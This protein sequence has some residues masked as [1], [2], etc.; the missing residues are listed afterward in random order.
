MEVSQEHL[1]RLLALACRRNV[2]QSFSREGQLKPGDSVIT[3]AGGQ[4]H[5]KKSDP[6][7]G[8]PS[9]INLTTRGRWGQLRRAVKGSLEL[10]EM[11][12]CLSLAI[13]AI[14]ANMGFPLNLCADT[15]IKAMKEH[16]D[17]R[18]GENT[19][20]QIHFVS[21]ND[22]AVHA[23]E[24][25]VRDKFGNHGITYSQ[26]SG[27]DKQ[28][29]KH[30][31][32]S[33]KLLKTNV[34]LSIQLVEG[35]IQDATTEVIVNVVGTELDLGKGAVS[36][37]VLGA[38]G[39]Q[40]Q[41]LVSE[42]RK[43][44]NFG[45]VI[46]TG[47]CKLKSNVVFHAVV[48]PWDNQGN[49]HKM[50]RGIVEDCLNEAHKRGLTSITFPAIGTG[51]LDF[52]KDLAA[53]VMIEEVLKFKKQPSG[54]KTVRHRCLSKRQRDNS[55]R[56]KNYIYKVHMWIRTFKIVFKDELKKR[57]STTQ[58]VPAPLKTQS[59]L[60]SKV[61]SASGMHEMTIGHVSVQV[62]SGDIT[63]ET[64]DVIVNSSNPSFDLKTGV[65]KAILDA[66]GPTV[67]HECTILGGQPNTG[68][69]MTK[70]GNLKC[71]KILHL[72]GRNDPQDIQLAV[73]AAL[74]LVEQNRYTSISFPALGTGQGNAQ[75]GQVADAMLDAVVD[76]V[77]QSAQSCLK[78]VRIVIFQPAM[79]KDFLS[80]M[81]KKA[82]SDKQ[83]SS[84]FGNIHGKLKGVV[85]YL[86]GG[87]AATKVT[88]QK[89]KNLVLDELQI[90]S[91][92]FHIC[93]SSQ[94]QVNKAITWIDELISNDYVETPITDRMILNLSHADYQDIGVIQSTMNVSVKINDERTS[95]TLE[96]LTKNVH[97][98]NI[99]IQNM[100][101]KIRDDEDIRKILESI[102]WQYQ[103]QGVQFQSFDST[104][105]FLLEQANQNN[106]P[107][108][109][110]DIRGRVY[111]VNMPDGPA[112]DVQGNTV[113]IRRHDM[114]KDQDA[115]NLPQHWDPMPSG[116]TCHT[117]PITPGTQEYNDV[118]QLFQA[119]CQQ[120]VIKIDRIQNASLWKSLQ[121]KKQDMDMMNG[122]QNNEKRLFHGAC[123]TSITAIN[124][125]GFNRSYAGK[126]AAYY[127]NG[128]YFAV[129]ASYSADDT[130]SKPDAQG[131]KCMYL[132]RVLTGDYTTGTSGMVVPPTKKSSI[133]QYD[134]GFPL[135]VD[136]EDNNVPKLKNKLL[137]Y[138]QSKK[139]SNGGEC[140]IQYEDGS[141]TAT[142]RFRTE[143]D[144]TRVVAKETHQLLLEEGLLKVTV[145][146]PGKRPL[147]TTVS[148]KQIHSD[149]R[150]AEEEIQVEAASREA[151]AEEPA[152]CST[153][154]VLENV[155]QDMSKDFM[156]M[157]VENICK[158]FQSPMKTQH[159]FSLEI[160]SD[161]CSA[162]VT[163]SKNNSFIT[164]CQTN[165]TFLSKNLSVRPLE[166]TAKVKVE[167]V[168]NIHSDVLL[169]YFENEGWEVEQI[170][171]D[172]EE[173][174]AVI[175]FKMAAAVQEIIKKK[176]LI[177]TKQVK[178]FPFYDSLGSALYGKDRPTLKLPAAFSE[179]I[180]PTISTY[181]HKK[182]EAAQMV[183]SPFA[184]LFCK[185]DLLSSSVS[186]SPLPTLLQQKGVKAKDI[187]V[188][189]HS[190]Q[191]AFTQ[192]LSRFKTLRLQPPLPAWEEFEAQIRE[193]V[194]NKAVEVIPDKAE[195][196]LSVSGFVDD[197]TRLEPTCTEL[198]SKIEKSFL[199]K[200]T[201]IRHEVKISNIIYQFLC[202][203]GLADQL[204]GKYPELKIAFQDKM[205][206][207]GLQHEVSEAAN[208]VFNR[209]L[210]VKRRKFKLD[211]SLLQFL[212]DE[213]EENLT[214]SV[215]TS[216]GI[217]AAVER[218]AT[219]LNI[220][221]VSDN[222]LTEAQG[223][224]KQ[225]LIS[226]YIDVKDCNVLKNPQW[227]DLV[228][229]LEKGT[230]T[231]LKKFAITMS[232]AGQFQRVTVAGYKDSVIPVYKKIEEHLY[233]YSQVDETVPV[234][235]ACIVRY[236]ETQPGSNKVKD[237]VKMHFGKESFNFIGPRE[238]V[239][240]CKSTFNALMSSVCFK[241]YQLSK[242]GAKEFFQENE[243]M[244]V[245]TL[246]KNTGCVVQLMDESASG[247]NDPH[248]SK[249]I[250]QLQTSDGIDIV[251]CKADLCSYPVDAVVIN[252]NENL[253][254]DGGITGAFAAAA[255][256][257]LQEECNTIL[258]KGQLKPGDSVITGAGGQ[259]YCKKVIHMVG[260]QYD[261]SN[262]QRTVGQLRRAVKGSLELAEKNGC[263]S[264]AISAISTNMGFPLNLC[265]DTIIKVMKEHCDDQCGENTLKQIHFVSTDDRAVQALETAVRDKFGNH[266]IT[267]QQ[268]DSDQ[269]LESPHLEMKIQ[270][271]EG[272]I[273]DA[274]T[275]VI[276]NVVGT[277]L[278]LG[279]GAISKAILRAAGSKLQMLVS[280]QRKTGNIGDVIVTGGCDLKSNVV[281]HTV[282]PSWDSQDNTREILRGIVEDC[283]NKA[284]KRGLTSITFPAIGTGN[285]G[286][287][288]D[289]AAS[290]MI[291]EILKLKKQPRG[292]KTV[293]IV[294]YPKDK[295]TIQCSLHVHWDLLKIV[296][297]VHSDC[298]VSQGL[299]SKVTSAS[300]M[301][302]MTIGHVRVQVL[303]GD[304]TKET[305]D[306]IINSSNPSFNHKKGVSKAIL[307]AAGPTV[308]HECTI[309]GGQPNTG[310][311]MTKPGNLKCQK[312]LHLSGCNDPQDIQKAVKAAL[313][314]V[315]QN[316][317]ISI[318]FPAL[319]TGQGNAQAGQVADAMLDA[320]VD[321]VAQSAQSC[322]KVVRIVIFQ[323]AMM[324]DFLTRMEKK[325]GSD[326]Q[327][328]SLVGKL[329]KGVVA[330]LSGG[331][332]ANKVVPQKDKE[333]VLD[334]LQI[335]SACFH[336]CGSSQAQV[337]KAKTWIDEL[338]SNDYVQ[339]PITDRMILNLSH[340]DYKDIGVIQS[341]MNVCV[342]INAERTCITL[343]GI[344]KYVHK[345]TTEIQKML[346]KVRDDD[347]IRKILESIQWQY[348]LQGVQFQSF[349]ST[350]NFLLEQAKQNLQPR[351][352]IDI[353]GQL[354]TVNMPDGS[355]TDVQGNT[356][357]IRR[358]DMQKDQ[359]SI[360]LPQHW[361]TMPSGSTWH[362]F[363]VNANTSEYNEVL[364]LFQATSKGTVITDQNPGLWKSLQIKRAEM[365][366][367]NGHQNNEKR[368]FH[369]V[370]HTKI[371]AIN[372][373]GFN[374]SFAGMNTGALYGNGTYF[375]VNA[376]DSEN[377]SKPDDQDQKFMYLCS[378]MTGDYTKGVEKMITPPTKG[379]FVLYDSVVDNDQNPQ[380]FV[381][382]HDTQAC[383]EYL[384]K[385]KKNK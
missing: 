289:L 216:N 185:V 277:D 83:N 140:Q 324:K 291:E 254:L 186:F 2:T 245:S 90:K 33:S 110:V 124:Q 250:Y 282:V 108:V 105:N 98:A 363:P 155:P 44:G 125:H 65:S 16:C 302:E 248:P 71:Q 342:K 137:K 235:S 58:S 200:N 167:D 162:V 78:V 32:N 20:K 134:N 31:P 168:A 304:I 37:A 45:D 270:I 130:Y 72:P 9:M 303:S 81:E 151:P 351:V 113:E 115:I 77:A 85:A 120:T 56:E 299:F 179:S 307:D 260:P 218:V 69:I 150:P 100:L 230:N 274:T 350:T 209:A 55:G 206:L 180:D 224:V 332:A 35:N 187:K 14:C 246:M 38:A 189:K 170:T 190:V 371:S 269:L 249:P 312:I 27:P 225:V 57:L 128:S 313:V 367:K 193:V 264:L 51:N 6:R 317:Y 310:M 265:A 54:L 173:Q 329:W 359:D 104:T 15:I 61:T 36:K 181:L 164:S 184:A 290:V 287:P 94:A 160:L 319:G 268:S 271:V 157:L 294:L 239:M 300:G 127:G 368:L 243:A 163:F 378:V 232:S 22:R 213:D 3:G 142:L 23:L 53:S 101:K 253:K 334:D 331:S 204:K 42:E 118:V 91:A 25:A 259:L 188:W 335:K 328:C 139:R 241:E 228:K 39:P 382:F 229:C 214:K 121:I 309:L 344:A 197:V 266:G 257:C 26:Q 107:R 205:I 295:E 165:R 376:E 82:G 10:A 17:D 237:T 236:I 337:N 327:N 129:N 215:F 348:Q 210:A 340:A 227:H 131:Q 102:E 138:F 361:A 353:Q 177:R 318:S 322:L 381:V 208:L 95:I 280:E 285:L 147:T 355:A 308:E 97:K 346:K 174:S 136:L 88:P 315:E 166:V 314:L 112:T 305:T 357:E 385:F 96:G 316:H 194:V 178:V 152:L 126:N 24:T 226:Q 219:G 338:I 375:A 275:E 358:Y 298:F 68:M 70:P 240:N 122:H 48:P 183:C 325:A 223:Q 103:L 156:E 252:S 258:Q 46:V 43:T 161:L 233:K 231:P 244:Y 384:I 75:A 49:A 306:V 60:F 144:R 153:S 169:L 296:Y 369:G 132:C 79:L 41:L 321:T 379:P 93:G 221:A 278:D 106:E 21:T 217:H 146:L 326:K 50:L 377:Y 247:Q 276:V 196:V 28:K 149:G 18:F 374:R 383:P 345:A 297:L 262:H 284:Q 159:E 261:Q 114:Q 84:F 341:T 73:E 123:H 11:N 330:Y 192:V 360:K 267:S 301:H 242:P 99:E 74:V 86:S 293:D 109:D 145:R 34:G 336:I 281:F 40:L 111:T 279:K 67:E 175:S 92:C 311:I 356:V 201:I 333:L 202:Q 234:K 52:P 116:S 66:A 198:M 349:D 292:L 207:N 63:K 273:K 89:D 263:L 212:K 199:R 365:E 238:D 171:K 195:G 64:T 255:G 59:S 47:G 8:G 220:L 352:D 30:Q 19:L 222:T 373:G 320:V 380:I 256:S 5:C 288:T 370:C 211:D 7:G 119:T 4:L 87:N 76:L 141:G 154:A 366:K 354:Y 286:F 251:V 172:E 362:T 339:T 323:P 343:E 135:V 203:D 364:G 80:R 143:E 117:V 133:L 158:K 191:Q 347:E 29:T 13:S 372:Q 272:K 182:Q 148:N 12:G 176:H 62:L 1:Q 283:L